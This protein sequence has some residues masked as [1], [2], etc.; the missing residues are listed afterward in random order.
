MYT[1]WDLAINN[2]DFMG[3]QASWCL[4]SESLSWCVNTSNNCW[5]S[6]ISSTSH[7]RVPACIVVAQ[8][9]D[10]KIVTFMTYLPSGNLT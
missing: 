4:S 2:R 5:G 8:H 7:N 9:G 3:F 10:I 1:L 6:W